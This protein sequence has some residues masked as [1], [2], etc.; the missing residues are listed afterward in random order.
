MGL[1]SPLHWVYDFSKKSHFSFY[2]PLT[3][4][5]SLSLLYEILDNICIVI[6]CCPVCDVINLEIDLSFPIKTFFYITTKSEQKCKHPS[7]WQEIKSI[8]HH[9]WRDFIVENKN[10]FFGRW[11]SGFNSKENMLQTKDSIDKLLRKE[12]FGTD[13]L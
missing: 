5:I 3:D 1:A 12:T 7:F 4:Q 6:I 8:F 9:F 11:E 10:N 2:I 13:I